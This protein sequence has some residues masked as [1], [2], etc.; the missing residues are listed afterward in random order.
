MP[1]ITI[2]RPEGPIR[3]TVHLPRSKSVSNRALIAA[4]L[5]GDL[6]CIEYLS[7]A[8]DTRILYQLLRER[9]RVMDCGLGGTTFRFLLAWAAVQAGKQHVITGDAKL[10]ERPH[11][12]LID[13]LR[14]LGATIERKEDGFHVNGA[15]L[16]G[17]TIA[18]DSPVS[19]QYL[20]ALML[21]APTME[22]GLQLEWRGTQLSRPYVEM[23]AKTMRHFGAQV[24][25]GE[26][27]IEV[28]HRSYSAVPFEVPGDWSAAAF[29][30]ELVALAEDAEVELMGLKRDGW[31][32][33]QKVAR[34]M[35]NLVSTTERV[36]GVQLTSLLPDV[37]KRSGLNTDLSATP[38]LFQPLALTMAA[39]GRPATFSGLD[40][41]SG[42]ESDRIA[43]VLNTLER[44][45]VGA[46]C[47]GLVFSI[48]PATNGRLRTSKP[49]FAVYGDHRM[50][51]A[52]APLALVSDSISIDDPDVVTKSYP[53]FWE[54]LQQ[55]GFSVEWSKP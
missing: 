47:D 41:L 9:P 1:H 42:K 15:R 7:E 23:T 51:M 16:V 29:W 4:S 2:R 27:L 34:L 53:D 37:A 5:A 28:K 40:N 18:F 11:E 55:A 14:K 13:A 39:L 20:S 36:D 3:A 32:G 12:D 46:A 25:V 24:E 45:G 8:D 52:L 22:K 54:D 6:G 33:D 17:G 43:A 48:P 44:I 49:P 10:L 26:T 21:V 19:S 35:A 30:Y 50:A 31:Q 38:D